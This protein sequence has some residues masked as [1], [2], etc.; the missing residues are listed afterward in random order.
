[1]LGWNLGISLAP[2]QVSLFHSPSGISLSSTNI[3]FLLMEQEP[4]RPFSEQDPISKKYDELQMGDIVLMEGFAD[5]APEY[6]N[7]HAKVVYIRGGHEEAELRVGLKLLE[8]YNKGRVTELWKP[9]WKV[10]G[11]EKD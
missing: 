10:V 6:N 1:M 7:L 2:T 9:R 4:Q 3:T 5:V 11:Q 8:G